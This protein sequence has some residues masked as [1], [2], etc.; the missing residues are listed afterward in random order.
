MENNIDLANLNKLSS[1][2]KN[3]SLEDQKEFL[4]KYNLNEGFFT[5]KICKKKVN[6]SD[7]K[8]INTPI[9]QN[10][11]DI[12][13]EDCQK[14]F[15]QE[16]FCKIVCVGCKE[17]IAWMPPH[18]DNKTGFEFKP[19]H[20]YHILYCPKCKPELFN[21]SNPVPVEII[22]SKLYNQKYNK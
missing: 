21:S 20:I 15:Q 19:N 13:C 22:E 3:L 8:V 14:S 1:E 7:I 11:T 10:V 6:L 17:V 16:K 2:F 12:I 5:C 18:K 4:K 9:L